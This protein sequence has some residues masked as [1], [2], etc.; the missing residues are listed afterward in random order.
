LASAKEI[1]SP[2]DYRNFRNVKAV[3]VLFILLG[4]VLALGGIAGI[5]QTI[6]GGGT[7]IGPFE[8]GLACVGAAGVVGA[9]SILRGSRRWAPVIYAMAVMY[10]FVFPVGTIL[11]YFL[12]SGLSRY[13]DSEEHI[14]RTRASGV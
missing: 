2:Q 12:L 14:R 4:G 11:S 5:A 1:L 7:K 9:I 3:A 8:A 6:L 10:L 13:F